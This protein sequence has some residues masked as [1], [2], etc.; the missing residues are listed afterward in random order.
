MRVSMVKALWSTVCFLGTIR[1]C[2]HSLNRS[3]MLSTCTWSVCSCVRLS[4]MKIGTKIPLCNVSPETQVG[5]RCKQVAIRCS[6][7][8]SWVPWVSID[9]S[10]TTGQ[11]DWC[12]NY[13]AANA[14]LHEVHLSVVTKRELSNTAQLSIF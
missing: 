7:L 14:V 3:S 1:C 5:E 9:E 6:R 13:Y 2:S 8:T 12:T 11:G 10:R 4:R